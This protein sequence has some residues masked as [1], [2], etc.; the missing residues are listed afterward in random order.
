MLLKKIYGRT[1][2][3]FDPRQ[4]V[5]FDTEG[6]EDEAAPSPAE[7]P[8]AAE[9]PPS[10]PRSKKRH[11]HGRGRIPDKIEREEKAH[12][13]SDAE[14]AALGG[15]EN[16]AELPPETS[17]QLDCSTTRRLTNVTGRLRS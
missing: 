1:S 5:L 8:A 6:G 16:L 14:K 13:L 10:S 17:E 4:G 12:D 2:E 3:K 15:V 9:A 7:P 11:R